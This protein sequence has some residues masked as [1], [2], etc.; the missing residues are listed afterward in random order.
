MRPM[1]VPML[2]TL[3]LSPA[4]GMGVAGAA[5]EVPADRGHGPDASTTHVAVSVPPRSSED[6]TRLTLPMVVRSGSTAT[7]CAVEVDD[8]RPIGDGVW[9]RVVSDTCPKPAGPRGGRG[10]GDAR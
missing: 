10:P 2:A 3:A 4:T 6:G 7:P 5:P 9:L 8:I 1:L